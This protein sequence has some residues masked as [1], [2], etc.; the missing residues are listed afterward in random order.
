MVY[1]ISCP[2]KEE[3][4]KNDAAAIILAEV[5]EPS[6]KDSGYFFYVE[7]EYNY[8]SWIPKAN[9]GELVDCVSLM[10]NH[11]NTIKWAEID[12][13]AYQYM[14]KTTDLWYYSNPYHEGTMIHRFIK[15]GDKTDYGVDE[16]FI[17]VKEPTFIK[18]N[19]WAS[20]K[21]DNP[22]IDVQSFDSVPYL[23]ETVLNVIYE[24]QRYL[25]T[26][27]KR[28]ILKG[29]LNGIPYVLNPWKAIIKKMLGMNKK[30]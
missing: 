10:L 25:P 7:L 2:I 30:K 19:H 23:I 12:N 11:V 24:F 15:D 4:R 18:S 3:D 14:P 26:W 21:C 27:K 5:F 28:A 20:V 17:T 8:G 22:W 16:P 29:F 1:P 9:V 13:V 6:L